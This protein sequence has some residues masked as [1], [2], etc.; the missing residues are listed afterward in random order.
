[1]LASLL[2]IWNTIFWCLLLYPFVVM[3]VLVP[4]PK[5]RLW[6]TQQ[7]VAI[8]E[9][10]IDGNDR[11]IR[12]TQDICWRVELPPNLSMNKNYLICSNHRSWV[13]IVALQHVFNHRI[14]FTRFFLKQELKWIPFLGAAWWALDFPFMKR[15]SKEYLAKYPEKRDEDLKATQ[16]VMQKY[17]QSPVS[18]L[19]FLEGTRLTEDKHRAQK[20]TYRHLLQPKTGGFAFALSALKDQLHA[21]LDVTIIYPQGQVTLSQLMRGHLKEIVVLVRELPIPSFL[22]DGNYLDDLQFRTRIQEWVRNLWL[23]KDQTIDDVLTKSYTVPI[24]PHPNTLPL[25]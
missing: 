7:M 14:P 13:D 5:F 2:T 11:T 6:C 15:H 8:A 23:V 4:F 10:W 17:K 19:N 3:K 25:D 9:K 21:I 20:S 12:W 18:I 22:T 24:M 1:M 16:K